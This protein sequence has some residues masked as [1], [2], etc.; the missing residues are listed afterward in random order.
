MMG[1]QN[2]KFKKIIIR[3]QITKCLKKMMIK[4]QIMKVKKKIQ[5]NQIN[6]NYCDKNQ[7]KQNFKILFLYHK[8]KQN[9]LN[10]KDLTQFILVFKKYNQEIIQK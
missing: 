5:Q 9:Y 10:L 3:N 4:N 1:L 8:Y 7:R 6:K 2:N